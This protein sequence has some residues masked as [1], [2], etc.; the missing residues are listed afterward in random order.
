MKPTRARSVAVA[1]GAV[2]FGETQR[3]TARGAN[4]L[5]PVLAAVAAIADS[6]PNLHDLVRVVEADDDGRE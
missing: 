1:G 4:G 3:E 6:D 2:I 5:R